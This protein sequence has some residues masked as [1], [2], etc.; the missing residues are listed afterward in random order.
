MSIAKSR[1]QNYGEFDEKLYTPLPGTNAVVQS[2]YEK[3]GSET[4]LYF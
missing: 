3:H 2:A 4:L 1:A